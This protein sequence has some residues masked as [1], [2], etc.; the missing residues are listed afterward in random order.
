MAAPYPY[1]VA[2]YI[3]GPGSG[4]AGSSASSMLGLTTQVPSVLEIAVPRN[5]RLPVAP[6]GVVFTKR[7]LWRRRLD[8]NPLEVVVIEVAS[9]WP[10]NVEDEWQNS[11]SSSCA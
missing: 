2:L 6:P 7:D 9:D 11:K 10:Q 1:D 3:A 4:Q 5:G 8:L